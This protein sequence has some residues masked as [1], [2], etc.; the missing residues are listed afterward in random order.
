MSLPEFEDAEAW[1]M[2]GFNKGWCGP[3]VCEI[4]DGIPTTQGEDEQLQDGEEPC[5]H[6][7][8]LYYDENHRNGVIGNHSPTTWRATN[9]GWRE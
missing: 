5:L 2:Y 9:R 8:R 1:M 7:I 3:P 4:H 6:I